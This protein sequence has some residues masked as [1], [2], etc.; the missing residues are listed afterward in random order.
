MKTLKIA[1]IGHRKVTQKNEL[2]KKLK[3]V[4][5]TLINEEDAEIFLFG[6]KGQFDEVSL[7]AVTELKQ[8]YFPLIERIYVRAIYEQI[9]DDY[10]SFLLLF[11]DKTFYPKEVK[12]AR[13]FSYVKR[14]EVMI[15]MC[16]ILITYY[17]KNYPSLTGLKSGTKVAVEYA[18]KKHKRI[19]NLF[20]YEQ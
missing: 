10:K 9:T 8:K 15:D 2:K 12:G 13:Y 4:I 3:K 14:N 17:D 19:I 11:Y 1:F 5:Y 16:D 6:G 7:A 20:E 18:I